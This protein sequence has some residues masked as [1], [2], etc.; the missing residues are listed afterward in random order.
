MPRWPQKETKIM[1]APETITAKAPRGFVLVEE[2]QKLVC[3]KDHPFRGHLYKKGDVANAVKGQIW[4]HHW[5]KVSRIDVQ[6]DATGKDV[7][8]YIPEGDKAASPWDQTET[9]RKLHDERFRGYV[10]C[11]LET[12]KDAQPGV[13]DQARTKWERFYP[14]KPFPVEG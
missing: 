7:A 6:K 14:G 10:L 8:K 13:Q 1:D 3:I 9:W 2:N 11:N 4:P 5:A 12:F